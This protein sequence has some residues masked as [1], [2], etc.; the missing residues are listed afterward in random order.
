MKGSMHRLVVSVS[1]EAYIACDRRNISE[2]G[3]WANGDKFE[4]NLGTKNLKYKTA[5]SVV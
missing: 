4:K 2:S 1:F 5:T 3:F